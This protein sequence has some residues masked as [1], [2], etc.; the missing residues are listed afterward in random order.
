MAIWPFYED[1]EGVTYNT[2]QPIEIATPFIYTK[3]I[4]RYEV[5]KIVEV[6]NFNGNLNEVCVPGIHFV[7]SPTDV[8]KFHDIKNCKV[9]NA[10]EVREY[11]NMPENITLD[12]S[13]SEETDWLDDPNISPNISSNSSLDSPNIGQ[14]VIPNG[15]AA[16][17]A[18]PNIAP[19]IV[20]NSNLDSPNIAPNIVSKPNLDS[21]NISPNT[22]YDRAED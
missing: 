8:F 1:S 14:I 3:N 16:I 19:N 5:G 10:Y 18:T 12:I 13:E 21:P 6:P 9:S 7:L 20:S 4:F 2:D 15:V 22:F 11:N 17:A